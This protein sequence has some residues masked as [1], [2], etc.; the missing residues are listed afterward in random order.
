LI[1]IGS[2]ILKI[3]LTSRGV[4]EGVLNALSGLP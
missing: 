2:T 4:L 3:A 1:P